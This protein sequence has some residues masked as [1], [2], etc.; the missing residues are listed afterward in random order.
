M[1]GFERFARVRQDR[2]G[3]VAHRMVLAHPDVVERTRA[4]A[5][6]LTARPDKQPDR[7]A[8]VRGRFR[9]APLRGRWFGAWPE[10]GMG[11]R[12]EGDGAGLAGLAGLG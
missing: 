5:E 11:V 8:S 2:G 9:R 1:I 4:L 12:G 7:G 6:T 10:E 3:H